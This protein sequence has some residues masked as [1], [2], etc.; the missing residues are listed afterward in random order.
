MCSAATCVHKL[1][2]RVRCP[3]C[4]LSPR[5]GHATLSHPALL[6]YCIHVAP[7]YYDDSCRVSRSPFPPLA[8]ATSPYTVQLSD[9][10]LVPAVGAYIPSIVK[11]FRV[12]FRVDLGHRH[13]VFP[14]PATRLTRR[15]VPR[16]HAS[17]AMG[18]DGRFPYPKEVWSPAGGWWPYPRAWK[19]NTA[20]AFLIT[21]ACAVPVFILSE[22]R[23]VR[24]QLHPPCISLYRVV[25]LQI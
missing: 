7:S 25:L 20:I 19:A 2:L 9:S 14:L 3:P 11:S 1:N 12:D 23:T 24:L 10:A 6:Q 13:F 16:P 22:N 18:A 21:A 15:S 17:N 8:A 5:H 4:F